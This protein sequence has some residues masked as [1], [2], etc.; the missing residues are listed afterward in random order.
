VKHFF[1]WSFSNQHQYM[2]DIMLRCMDLIL[3]KKY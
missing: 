3:I 2:F 1:I